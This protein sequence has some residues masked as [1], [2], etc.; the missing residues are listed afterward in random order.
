MDKWRAKPDARIGEVEW[1]R[2]GW[3]CGGV[4]M[5]KCVGG[6]NEE[7]VIK[8]EEDPV[9]KRMRDD[10]DREKETN[11]DGD[12]GNAADEDDW[13]IK[14][15]EQLVERYA[16]M[17]STG[18][19][20]G[21]LWRRRGCDD[22]IQRLPLVHQKI[23]LDGLRMRYESLL[24]MAPELP[25][26]VSTPDS[27]DVLSIIQQASYL[28]SAP[29]ETTSTASNSS[30]DHI[31]KS[32]LLLALFG[33]QAEDNHISGLAT[34][35]ACFRRLGL[36]LFKSPDSSMD[37]LDV[38]GEHREY[39]PWVNPLSQNGGSRRSSLDGLAG[40]EVLLRAVKAR[41]SRE[42]PV[43]KNVD[44][45]LGS[46]DSLEDGGEDAASFVETV[47]GED[48]KTRDET[49][50]QRWAKLKRLKQVFHVKK[51]PGTS[52]SSVT[53]TTTTTA[54]AT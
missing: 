54:D 29:S 8:L 35:T 30:T 7:I 44:D 36:W 26:Q 38:I 21:C 14:A 3:S 41:S 6:C 4:E 1:A 10:E 48:E 16:E 18:H 5:V 53:T 13:R 12:K 19:A 31:N 39:C 15:Q 37:R 52:G 42:P 9:E 45:L 40:W 23:A 32:G 43:S 49:D 50:R 20:E 25:P 28:L 27:L 2:R 34:C 11:E 46:R 47:V 17:I 24:A 33:W 22:T 51:R